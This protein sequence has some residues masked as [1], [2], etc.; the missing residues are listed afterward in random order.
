M[1]TPYK[2]EIDQFMTYATKAHA[3]TNHLYDD[4][5]PYSFHLRA[6]Q[7]E[8]ERFIHILY[9]D[10]EHNPVIWATSTA[11]KQQIYSDIICSCW[12]H[13]L[14]EDAR[15]SYNDVANIAGYTVAEICRAL[16]CYT[17]GKTREERMPDWI[18]TLI[19]DTENADF[20]KLCDRLA[21]V[22]Y[23]IYMGSNMPSKYK[24]ENPKFIEKVTNRHELLKPMIDEL[25]SLFKQ[26][27]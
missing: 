3:D 20:V 17:G 6:V 12:G 10:I 9:E 16:T 15:Q 21:N 13:D 22:R 26:V 5:L 8:A 4:E 2:V 7:R 19:R 18:Y 24:K 25:E 1:H 14:I 23:G 27:V 11:R